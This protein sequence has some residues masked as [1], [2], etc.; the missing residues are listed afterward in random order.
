MKA[1]VRYDFGDASVFGGATADPP[2]FEHARVVVLP[3]PFDR[4]TTYVPGTRTPHWRKVKNRRQVDVVVG[5]YRP[6]TGNRETTFGSL[7]VGVP[8]GDGLRFSGTTRLNTTN[9]R[10]DDV[11]VSGIIFHGPRH[12][13]QA[14]SQCDRFPGRR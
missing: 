14:A 1:P 6:G 7:L 5:G 3:I 8:D 2:A 13:A 10:P 9:D 11:L 4:T 12:L